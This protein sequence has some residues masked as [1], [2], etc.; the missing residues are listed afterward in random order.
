MARK[1]ITDSKKAVAYCR[2]STGKQDTEAQRREI[3]EW[4][5]R[6]GVTIAAWAEDTAPGDAALEDRDGLMEAL[7]A[8]KVHRAGRMVALR[9]DRLDR[10]GGIVSVL[11]EQELAKMGA[12]LHYVHGLNGDDPTTR[13]VRQI[14]AAVAQF[15]KAM[16]RARTKAKLQ[17]R[18]QNL[19]RVGG[20]VP[21][22]FMLGEGDQLVLNPAEADAARL[23]FDLRSV[24]MGGLKIARALEAAGHHPR[25]GKW[26]AGNVTRIADRLL[27]T[28]PKVQAPSPVDLPALIL[29]AIQSAPKTPSG[30]VELP[31]VVR[32]LV[33]KGHE[34]EAIHEAFRPLVLKGILSLQVESGLQRFSPEELAL[35]P[36]GLQGSRLSLASIRH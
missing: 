29:A 10:S 3:Q 4:A 25:R 30:L 12:S 2:V 27:K 5:N 16:I 1:P 9:L 11:V 19:Q 17:T 36:P 24:G 22:G 28:L 31:P 33:A 21:F 7:E 13:M 6:E 23:I 20:E 34:L 26:D 15:E 35:C 14:L 8:V 32:S 18:V